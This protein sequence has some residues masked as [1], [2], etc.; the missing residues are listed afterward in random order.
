MDYSRDGAG[1]DWD[2]RYI[3]RPETGRETLL[4]AAIRH[5]LVD[6]LGSPVI[7]ID[8]AIYQR[9]CIANWDH[10]VMVHSRGMAELVTDFADPVQARAWVE[11]RAVSAEN[12]GALV[13]APPSRVLFEEQVL[14][15]LLADPG[16]AHE[17]LPF[18]GLGADSFTADARYEIFSAML[19]EAGRGS[20]WDLQMVLR[21]IGARAAL[22]PDVARHTF[23]GPDGSRTQAYCQRLALTPVTAECAG[24]AAGEINHED[25][26]A[27]DIVDDVDPVTRVHRQRTG[28]AGLRLGRADRPGAADPVLR[29][30]EDPGQP[31][32]VPRA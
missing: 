32:P 29:P 8:G 4:A 16:A 30:P 9:C 1:R 19:T 31:G 11:D 10:A 22:L 26:M 5:G 21:A 18:L 12:T 25:T 28:A 2:Q 15:G 6:K 20:G 24:L 7:G 13:P 23:A 3:A 14:A 27:W 17:R